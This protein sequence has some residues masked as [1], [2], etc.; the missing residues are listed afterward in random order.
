MLL[1]VH[2]IPTSSSLKGNVF[3][4]S[5]WETENEK[6]GK[7]SPPRA[8]AQFS[9]LPSTSIPGPSGDLPTRGILVVKILSMLWKHD[10]KDVGID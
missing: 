2:E 3:S 7:L 8:M 10:R 4:L 1:E 6:V 9:L 5:L